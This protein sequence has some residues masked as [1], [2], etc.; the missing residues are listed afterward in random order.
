MPWRP[1]SGQDGEAVVT[2]EECGSISV[3]H[4]DG[5][6]IVEMVHGKANPI[7]TELLEAFDHE[8]AE[9]ATSPAVRSVVVTGAGK[10]FS[11]GVDLRRMLDEEPA[12]AE[13]F[14]VA[15]AETLTTLF[16]FPKPTVAAINGHAVAGGCL[17][18]C[19][20]DVRIAAEGSKMGVIELSVGVSFPVVALEILRHA[21]GPRMEG[22]VFGAELVDVQTAIAAGIVHE[23]VDGARL[24]DRAVEEARRL[25]AMDAR[26]F[27]LTKSSM[28]AATL[29][30]IERAG[31]QLDKAVIAQ[32]TDPETRRQLESRFG[33]PK[34]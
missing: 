4:S 27:A 28:R 14:I 34:G 26:A 17:I 19:A 22:L 33:A 10:V 32:W 30:R 9:C 16:A 12:Y 1:D 23:A 21:A 13:S 15:L 8:L 5:V 24:L 31:P 25:G 2:S 18:A 7:D 3:N 11:G 29:E 6:A 20:C